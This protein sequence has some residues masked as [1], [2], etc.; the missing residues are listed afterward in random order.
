MPRVRF[1]R[2]QKSNCQKK[3]C[4]RVKIAEYDTEALRN[5]LERYLKSGANQAFDLHSYKSLPVSFAARGNDL[6]KMHKWVT[7]ILSVNP[8]GRLLVSHWF[9]FVFFPVFCVFCDLDAFHFSFSSYPPNIPGSKLWY[10]QKILQEL[11]IKYPGM[12]KIG[13]EKIWSQGMMERFNVVLA[14]LR[15]VQDGTRWIQCIRSMGDPEIKKLQEMV[16]MI[17]E[18]DFQSLKKNLKFN[19]EKMWMVKNYPMNLI[20]MAKLT[21]AFN[22]LRTYEILLPPR[23]RSKK[24][25]TMKKPA[26]SKISS[27]STVKNTQLKTKEAGEKGNFK[28]VGKKRFKMTLASHQSYIQFQDEG[29]T[30]VVFVGSLQPEPM[31]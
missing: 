15:R 3:K 2:D 9:L 28:T 7:A 11:A 25:S 13:D 31:P 10:T 1:Q 16:D 20:M 30:E 8:Q 27:K 12:C 23:T 26:A 19:L 18:D 24:W 21:V 22:F 17:P 5:S 14:H 4:G 29:E 6:V